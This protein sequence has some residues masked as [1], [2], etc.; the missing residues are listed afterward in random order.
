[1]IHGLIFLSL[2]ILRTR[3]S[4]IQFWA[5]ILIEVIDDSIKTKLIGAIICFLSNAF[6]TFKHFHEFMLPNFSN[7]TFPIK[8]YPLI[9]FILHIS[10]V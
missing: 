5:D 7:P 9:I 8:F 3:F 1:M 4:K 6:I 10:S 2:K